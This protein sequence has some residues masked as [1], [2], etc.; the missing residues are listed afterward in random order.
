MKLL[1]FKI[2]DEVIKDIQKDNIRK[3]L[4]HLNLTGRHAYYQQGFYGSSSTIAVVDT[5]VSPI[6]KELVDRVSIFNGGKYVGYGKGL[7][8]AGHGTHVAGTI[9]GL[10]VGIA[11]RA[12]ILSAKVLDA[13]GGGNFESIC[14]ALEDLKGW[15]D[16]KGRKLTAVS[17]SLSA[18]AE[19]F[20]TNSGLLTRFETIIK[21]LTEENIAVI[22]SA[23]NTGKKDIRF[24]ACFQDPITVGAIDLE[25]MLPADFSTESNE[26]DVC[27]AG[28]DVLSSWYMGDYILMSGTSMATPV[29]SGIAA[30]IA[31][32]FYTLFKEDI[33]EQVLYW[34][35]KMNTKGFGA[36]VNS[37][38]GA[39]FCSL[40][41]IEMD[42]YTRIGNKYWTLN[43]KNQ[44][45]RAPIEVV[46]PGVTSLPAR[47]FVENIF[48]GI[49]DWNPENKF[50]RFRV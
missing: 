36:K 44:D 28:T 46:K 16:N 13:T 21:E 43:N 41:P 7:D 22:C 2:T 3:Y 32:K 10:N 18:P 47:E 11:P 9:A 23:G 31:D 48:G 29:I 45:L 17:M 6:H 19:F 38:T 20:S 35:L 27:Q 33:P 49:V 4:N 25:K 24:P 5:G 30:L 12:K 42:L 26:V 8:D 14:Q 34:M 15:R 50:A 39:G 37:K 1:D 40:Q